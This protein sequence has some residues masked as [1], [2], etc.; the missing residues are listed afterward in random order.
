MSRRERQVD[1]LRQLCCRGC[2]ARAIDLAFEHFAQFGRDDVIIDLLGA[3]VARVDA[4][5]RARQRFDELC[6]PAD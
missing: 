2:V 5:A 3:A 6:P 4:G 1:E